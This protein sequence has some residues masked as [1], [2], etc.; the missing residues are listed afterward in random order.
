MPLKPV[1]PVAKTAPSASSS[2]PLSPAPL[3][4]MTG[5]LP[6]GT[7]QGNYATRLVAT[8]GVPPYSWDAT[9]G[10]IAPG[11]TLR[12]SAGTLSGIP[13]VPGGFSFTARVQ[14]ATGASLSTRLSMNISDTSSAA[15]SD[16][17]PD[18]GSTDGGAVVLIS[19]RSKTRR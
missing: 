8:G 13:F 3:R 19:D 17:V 2:R 15:A 10:Q 5:A 9:A 6:D 18:R 14:D 7:M 1:T 12:S 4:I 11:L 16:V